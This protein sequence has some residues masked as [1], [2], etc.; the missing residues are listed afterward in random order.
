MT[1]HIEQ[2]FVKEKE[3]IKEK[4]IFRYNISIGV[5]YPNLCDISKICIFKP[6][7][8]TNGYI[9]YIDPYF[10]NCLRIFLSC[11]Y[12]NELCNVIDAYTLSFIQD[13]EREIIAY[14][15]SYEPV[16]NDYDCE[17]YGGW[18]AT[19]DCVLAREKEDIMCN[20]SNTFGYGVD[21]KKLYIGDDKDIFNCRLM[22]LNALLAE[23]DIMVF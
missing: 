16:E 8:F 15:L 5:C 22:F 1:S 6:F 18:V 3:Y 21:I 13:K 2:P 17:D 7:Y 4:E 12:E 20:F 23:S 19:S 11:K 14:V 9:G 10:Q